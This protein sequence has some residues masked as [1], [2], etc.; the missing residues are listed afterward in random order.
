MA[1]PLGF[2]TL[3]DVAEL[4]LITDAHP[5]VAVDTAISN[6]LLTRVAANELPPM[7]RVYVPGRVVAFGSQDRT[8]H[9]YPQAVAAVREL[10]FAAIERL[11]G[12]R[13]AV[14]HE[15]TIAFAW[16]TPHRDAKLGIERRFEE[17]A[18]IVVDALARVGV[19][20]TI[21][22]TAGEYCPGR[23]SVAAGGRKVMG[24]GQRLIRGAAHVGGVLVVDS[25]D[26]VNRP[27]VPAYDHLEYEWSPAATGAVTDTAAVTVGAVVDAFIEAVGAVGHDVVPSTWDRATLA[28]ADSLAS[29]H[30]PAIP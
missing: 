25:P 12:G 14:F 13:A 24:V 7:L 6:A 21:G 29:S 4:R 11:A 9:G 15:G 2:P 16:S 30:H 23:F 1:C 3:P 18:G 22:E 19:A 10:G 17:L 20:A 28:L 8:R 26:L 27:L 5:D